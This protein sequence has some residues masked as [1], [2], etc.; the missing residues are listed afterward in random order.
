MTETQGHLQEFKSETVTFTIEQKGECIARCQAFSSPDLVKKAQKEAIQRVSKEVVL[1]GF[2]KGKAPAQLIVKKFPKAVEEKWQTVLADHTFRACQKVTDI[3]ILNHETKINFHVEKCS[4]DGGAQIT[5]TFETEPVVPEIHLDQLT[6]QEVKRATIDEAQ[7]EKTLVDI[8]SYFI[9]WTQGGGS[10]V[11]EGDFV[12]IQLDVIDNDPPETVF[13]NARF[14][15]KKEKMAGW[16]Y[17]MLIGM[18][19]QSTREG[20]SQPNPEASSTEKEEMPPKKVRITLKKIEV[21]HY[22]PIDDALAQK[23]GVKDVQTL[24]ENLTHLLNKQ[25]DEAVQNEYRN[26]ITTYLLETYP[27]DLPKT[28]RQN[29]TAT[30]FNQLKESPPLYQHF[31]NQNEKEKREILTQIESQGEKALRLFYI[32]RD[33]LKRHQ[34]SILPKEVSAESLSPL[35]TLFQGADAFYEK[36]ENQH[37]T[38]EKITSRLILKKAEDFLISKAKII[39]Q[40]PQV[41]NEEKVKA[42]NGSSQ[43]PS[44]P[45]PK[46]E[47]QEENLT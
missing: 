39:T 22:P 25:A 42:T 12:V 23:V 4:I 8:Q 41:D 7:I 16:M 10:I 15:V 28:L 36:Q 21:P 40:H 2:R 24:K 11:Q 1:P 19:I 5:Y 18:D 14:E 46:S 30:R 17:E 43:K 9:E 20:I 29:E 6:L 3:P 35:E 47:P 27:F 26:Q 45:C 31:L 44:T 37:E 13:S 38:A 33:I 32:C 34:L